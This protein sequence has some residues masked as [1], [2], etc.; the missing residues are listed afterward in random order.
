MGVDQLAS[1]IAS[2]PFSTVIYLVHLQRDSLMWALKAC[3]DAIPVTG[4][5][6]AGLADEVLS[7]CVFLLIYF[8]ICTSRAI[9]LMLLQ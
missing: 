3:N 1:L 8:H 4:V 2:L 9:E 7:R 6:P 5:K